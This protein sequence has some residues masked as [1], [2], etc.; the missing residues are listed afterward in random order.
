MDLSKKMLD[1]KEDKHGI[2]QGEKGHTPPRHKSYDGVSISYSSRV[3]L[4]LKFWLRIH[5]TIILNGFEYNLQD[6]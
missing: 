4:R 5:K 1:V 3:K 6:G 2:F